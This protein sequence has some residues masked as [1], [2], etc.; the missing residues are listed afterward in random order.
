MTR[1]EMLAVPV[2]AAAPQS[3]SG[4]DADF[5]D[6]ISAAGAIRSKQISSVELTTHVFSRI[7]K[8]NPKLNAFVYQMR[9]EAMARARQADASLAKGQSLGALHGVPVHVKESFAVAGR[10]CT[11]GLLPFKDTKAPRNSAAVEKL[12]GA[13]A[14]LIGA[15]N[16]PVNL[17]DYQ[18]DNPI[19]G[20]TSNPWD[21][22][23]TPGGSS[24]GTAAALAAGLG[25]LSVGSDI[26]GS[27]RVPAHFCGVYGHKPTLGL[28]SEA[29]QLPG[30]AY[31]DSGFSTELAVAGPLSRSAR[32][33]ELAL[34]VLA[35]PEGH[36]AIAWN[37]KLPPAR[38]QSLRGVRVGYVFDDPIAPVSDDLKPAFENLLTALTK[39]GAVVK[40]GW[41]EGV[42]PAE[43]NRTY[44]F[45]LAA[46]L[47]AVEP[48]K[49]QAAMR[50]D[51]GDP[52]DDAFAA[53]ALSSHAEWMS[54]NLRRFAYRDQWAAHFRNVDVFLSP[55]AFRG[56]F[57][58]MRQGT[59]ATRSLGTRRYA[60]LMNWI[61]PATLTGCPAT[62]AP[63]GKTA[64]GLPV[65]VQIM[66]PL[67]EDATPIAFADALA[68]E[69][70]GFTPPPGFRP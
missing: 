51:F 29:G 53:G 67:W 38:H 37:W 25:F 2:F 1:R 39:A 35:G 32:D 56:A 9:E 70:G 68:K 50:R 55:V 28:V 43:L 48:P 69:I 60:D 27:I 40:P 52:K 62:A 36:R 44:Q 65:G 64:A 14:V 66:G 24:G 57:P 58:H 11:W 22:K 3:R 20:T 49:G 17:M 12:L 10:P 19:Y 42:K 15:T 54:Q 6:A 26:G 8:Y 61:P 21:V 41:P 16:V 34:R 63:I 30:G 46:V 31:H 4:F 18:S 5:G 33:L 47:Y 13:G 45:L 23:L 59:M 7:D